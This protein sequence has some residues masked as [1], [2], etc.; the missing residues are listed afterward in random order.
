MMGE[1]VMIFYM[2]LSPMALHLKG[3]VAREFAG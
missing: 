2:V 1:L 3:Y